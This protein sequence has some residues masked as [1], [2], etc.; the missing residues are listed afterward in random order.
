MKNNIVSILLVILLFS[1]QRKR[2]PV[3]I[4]SNKTSK[5]Q[6]FVLGLWELYPD[7][8]ANQGYHKLDSVLVI[9]DSV[10]NWTFACPTGFFEHY[11]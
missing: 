5:I 2:T 6:S 1:C 3:P 4:D 10:N 7:W 8:A 9:S 11:L